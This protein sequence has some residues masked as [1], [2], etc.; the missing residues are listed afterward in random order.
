MMNV[1]FENIRLGNTSLRNHYEDVVADSLRSILRRKYLIAACI[2][3]AIVLAG[4]LVS[5]LPR[6]YTAQALI[7]PNVRHSKVSSLEKQGALPSATVSA[8][9]VV[10]SEVERI[11]SQ[12]ISIGVVKMLKLDTDP[13][14]ISE[15]SGFALLRKL[16]SI[17]MPETVYA[18]KLSRAVA[19]FQNR[20]EIKSDASTYVIAVRFTA[21]SPEFAAAAANAVLFVYLRAKEKDRRTLEVRAAQDELARLSAT[22]GK[23]HPSV[24]LAEAHL[25]RAKRELQLP[26]GQLYLSQSDW[27][28]LAEPNSVPSGPAGKT[29]LGIAAVLG[30]LGGTCAAMLLDRRDNGF[31]ASDE[32]A[33]LTSTRCVGLVPRISGQRTSVSAA[34]L[35]RVREALRAIAVSAGLDEGKGLNKVAMVTTIEGPEGAAQFAGALGRVLASGGQRVLFIDTGPS[36][37]P[38]SRADAA[39]EGFVKFDDVLAD[40]EAA[41][42]FFEACENNEIAVLKV[43]WE[44]KTGKDYFAIRSRPLSRFIAAARERYDVVLIASSLLLSPADTALIGRESDVRLFAARWNRTPRQAVNSAIKRLREYGVEINGVVLTDANIVDTAPI[45]N[46]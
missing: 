23:R 5:V 22:Y 33:A 1:P 43:A 16:K 45:T 25:A 46:I 17:V 8:S 26:V 44:S 31:K 42:S 32:V 6:T 30:L 41:R 3:V 18:T 28:V 36:T 29:I 37:A 27:T 9:A 20:L 19:K 14:F 38:V 24:V 13:I 40:E 39:C 7:Y 21:N 34:Q 35:P 10:R 12:E 11:G 2:V 15:P 4:L